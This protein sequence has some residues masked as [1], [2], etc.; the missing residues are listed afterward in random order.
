MDSKLAMYLGRI[1]LVVGLIVGL[2]A[3][4]R[5]PQQLYYGFHWEA[6]FIW[7][8]ATL[9]S[10][11]LLFGISSILAYQEEVLYHLKSIRYPESVVPPGKLGNS[12]MSLDS[13]ADYKMD[14]KE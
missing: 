4:F 5:D 1:V 9:V 2:F 6:S 8:C 10:S 14:S 11:F 12:K 3:G 13:L 7:W